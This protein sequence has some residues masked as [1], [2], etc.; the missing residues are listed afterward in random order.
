MVPK[1]KARTNSLVYI[2]IPSTMRPAGLFQLPAATP[3][4]LNLTA[5]GK[6]NRAAATFEL[7]KWF[8]CFICW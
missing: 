1:V 3:Y 5:G 4:I 8:W 7:V 2:S 6:L